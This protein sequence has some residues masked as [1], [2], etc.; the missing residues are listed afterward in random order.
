[1]RNQISTITV[2]IVMALLFLNSCKKE[3]LS[4]PVIYPTGPEAIL[5]F[6]RLVTETYQ[7]PLVENDSVNCPKFISWQRPF[8]IG[9]TLAVAV[10]QAYGAQIIGTKPVLVTVTSGLGDSETY[11]LKNNFWPCEI[12][13]ID[14]SIYRSV[15]YYN[16]KPIGSK[17]HPYPNNGELEI[18][19]TG[20]TLIASYNSYSTGKMIYDTVAIIPK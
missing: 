17:P 20:D 8:H 1:M 6:S 11:L 3:E 13:A 2:I 16:T 14:I 7:L 18:R 9:D 4:Q 15:I 10:S 19:T 12:I 5:A